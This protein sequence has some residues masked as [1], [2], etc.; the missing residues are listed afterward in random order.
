MWV[1]KCERWI[2]FCTFALMEEAKK[3][4]TS[5]YT[6]MLRI[7]KDEME[8]VYY[9][10]AEDN[11][12]VRECIALPAGAAYVEAVEQA[13]Y[14]RELLLQPFK[15][16]YVVLPSPRTVIVPDEVASPSNNELCYSTLYPQHDDEIISCRMPQ[17]GA[18]MV[19]GAEAR[20]V[21]FI[22][23]TFDNPTLLHPLVPLCEYFYRKSRIGNQQKMYVHLLNGRMDV[24]CYN[25]DGLMLANTYD[26][27]Q[28]QD[29]A[30]HVLRV[31]EQ[32]GM[33]QRHDEVQIVGDGEVRREMSALLRNYIL[34]VL[35]V[36]FPSHCHVLGSEA[37]ALPFDLT[38][39]TL[40][41]L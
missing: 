33:D 15:R 5:R 37:I 3:I 19:W 6:L 23:R 14:D 13:I 38:A 28:A 1:E 9:Q 29:A 21:S 31:W 10:A 40:C 7:G 27:K 4:D 24:V 41:E 8:C 22:Q 17:V 20:L 39:L 26:Y 12:L 11:S 30:Y 36:I 35:P 2:V 16:V 25:K 34:T 18:T 32:L